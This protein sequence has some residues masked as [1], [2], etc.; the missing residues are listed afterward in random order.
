MPI[1]AICVCGQQFLA[2]DKDAGKRTLCPSCG[3]PLA[4]P[5]SK[6]M[7]RPDPAPRQQATPV[8]E[9]AAAQM[10]AA[11][12]AQ[13]IQL[14]P[15][16][17]LASTAYAA[18]NDGHRQMPR[19]R[20]QSNSTFWMVFAVCGGLF[21]L[22]IVVMALIFSA[23]PIEYGHSVNVIRG[24]SKSKFDLR[25]Y[26][27]V[28]GGHSMEMARGSVLI[29][30]L[31]QGVKIDGEQFPFGAVLVG[32][33]DEKPRF[34]VATSS[35]R[36]LLDQDMTILGTH[37]A[38]GRMS[39]PANG[40][41]SAEPPKTTKMAGD[42]SVTSGEVIDPAALV[43]AEDNIRWS[44]ANRAYLTLTI[45][46]DDFLDKAEK[47]SRDFDAAS[48]QLSDLMDKDF[49]AGRSSTARNRKWV[50]LDQYLEG[51][52]LNVDLFLYRDMESS[53]PSDA[54]GAAMQVWGV[55]GGGGM[56][57]VKF[58]LRLAGELLD[59]GALGGAVDGFIQYGRESKSFRGAKFRLLPEKTDEVTGDPAKPDKPAPV[60]F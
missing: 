21:V 53:W 28:R 23:Q 11:A 36:I 58:N 57:D 17:G 25:G 30:G 14:D 18:S 39:V 16:A 43:T 37:Y 26:K 42:P 13:A 1:V 24:I 4:I 29:V 5:T 54:G 8:R 38:M 55:R 7:R 6:S 41:L 10:I 40:I 60:D 49:N 15:L 50:S 46:K 9:G 3:Q 32:V 35:D 22:F 34:R 45:K 20:T 19:R 59:D 47:G 44:A 2:N 51:G 56:P 33:Q 27:I 48:K 31:P 52:G 12:P